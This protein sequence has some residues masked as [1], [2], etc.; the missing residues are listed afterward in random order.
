MKRIISIILSCS[1]LMNSTVSCGLFRP[2]IS[3]AKFTDDNDSSSDSE[4]TESGSIEGTVNEGLEL[5]GRFDR[6]RN[7][8]DFSESGDGDKATVE[9]SNGDRASLKQDNSAKSSTQGRSEVTTDAEVDGAIESESSGS[10]QEGPNSPRNDPAIRGIIEQS[11]LKNAN[12]NEGNVGGGR[13]DPCDGCD[14]N[15][16]G[17]SGGA[18]SEKKDIS[19]ANL[20]ELEAKVNEEKAKFKGKVEGAKEGNSQARNRVSNSARGLLDEHNAKVE[21]IKERFR[22]KGLETEKK[23][24]FFTD[25]QS[26][27]GQEI[28]DAAGRFNPNANQ[29]LKD[30][31]RKLLNQ[32]DKN[33]Y[34]GNINAANEFLKGANKLADLSNNPGQ[35]P[36]EVF[37]PNFRPDYN[38]VSFDEKNERIKAG[39][40]G[41]DL[42]GSASDLAADNSPAANQALV[43]AGTLLDI[44][45]G[46]ARFSSI[47]DVPLSAMEL[48][49]GKTLEFDANGNP[50]IVES[51]TVTRAAAALTLGLT[52][53]AFVTTGGLAAVGVA[54][55][56]G[57]IPG[58]LK[59]A[60][61][62]LG[63]LSK[64]E[65][66][67]ETVADVERTVEQLADIAKNIEP[68]KRPR[69]PQA[70]EPLVFGN[71]DKIKSQM[72]A[73]GW[74][75][76]D[77]REALKTEGIPAVG[78]K[79]QAT[80]YV[81]PR[82]GKSVVV[83]NGTG[84]IFHVGGEGFIYE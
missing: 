62:A 3:I 72:K 42:Y 32:A 18:G 21:K 44:A 78:K 52:A 79:G 45:L 55:A 51:S 11:G 75:E 73:R 53:A 82:T 1:I 47:V 24:Q 37:D 74:T 46:A 48:F 66:A 22:N 43:E 70:N 13:K 27:L 76:S 14:G 49:T 19:Y 10:N 34:T 20:D 9:S 65:K 29:N 39:K 57:F 36:A 84:E 17:G 63:G 60:R 81:N 54:A 12:P 23:V 83:D 33:A 28:R 16:G 38:S 25:P 80:R 50:M 64:T 77:I 69:I 15:N 26:R 58:L 41:L 2:K 35:L 56:I 68:Q 30:I 5:T 4:K 31:H 7:T 59:A 40:V 67:A 61:K 8:V 6:E 71:P